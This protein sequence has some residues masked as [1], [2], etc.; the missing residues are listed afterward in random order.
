[1]NRQELIP[2]FLEVLSRAPMSVLMASEKLGVRQGASCWAIGE[3]IAENKLFYCGK[4]VCPINKVSGVHFWTS[5]PEVY[6]SFV[7][8]CIASGKEIPVYKPKK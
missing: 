1:M 3:L 7:S 8:D 2:H 5:S 6:Q 4:S